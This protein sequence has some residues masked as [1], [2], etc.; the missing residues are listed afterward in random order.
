MGSQ[1][2]YRKV[3]RW[4]DL[5]REE[6]RQ[7]VSRSGYV[8]DDVMLVMN[9]VDVGMAL[10]PHTHDDFDQLAYLV[11]GKANYFVD[12]VPHLLTASS[13]L[14]VPAGS[15]HYIEPLEGPCLNLDIF[16]PPREDL[17]H[18]AEQHLAVEY[19]QPGAAE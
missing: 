10:N 2:L 14:L 11:T 17:K 9:Y 5:P 4:E 7:G 8:T 3:V 19:T 16:T 6:V 18:L 13:M 15:P 1:E 12:G